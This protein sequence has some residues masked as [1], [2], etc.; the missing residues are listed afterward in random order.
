MSRSGTDKRKATKKVNVTA[1][2]HALLESYTQSKGLKMYVVLGNFI[3]QGVE[4]DIFDSDWAKKAKG[5]NARY[6]F[7]DKA[8]P[9][10]A[11]AKKK[12]ADVTG[13]FRCVCARPGKPPQILDLS[14]DP[15]GAKDLCAKCTKHMEELEGIVSYEEQIKVLRASV[16]KGVI[17]DVPSCVRGG[18]LSDDG[19]KLYCQRS[20]DFFKV[21]RCK[22]LQNGA[23]CKELRWTR[24]EM[25]GQLP[26]EKK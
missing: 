26:E 4:Y 11:Y 2:S 18:R 9:R 24:I 1:E 13:W 22:T 20:G 14:Q 12:E 25:K 8:C 15:N 3:A 21:E 23:N 16:K 17:V 7:L 19:K 5:D 10:L 6:T